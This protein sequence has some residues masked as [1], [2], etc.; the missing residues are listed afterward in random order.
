MSKPTVKSNTRPGGV[1]YRS[2]N[3]GDTFVSDYDDTDDRILQLLDIEDEDG[4]YK[5][6]WLCDGRTTVFGSKA[7]VYLRDIEYGSI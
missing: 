5:S 2:L 1:E 7:I 6:V 3:T 4:D